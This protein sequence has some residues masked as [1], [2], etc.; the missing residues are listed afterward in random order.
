[1]TDTAAVRERCGRALDARRLDT[2]QSRFCHRFVI[3][4]D[5]LR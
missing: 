3:I 4:E 2:L 5:A 1:M